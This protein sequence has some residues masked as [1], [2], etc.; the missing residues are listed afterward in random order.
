MLGETTVK[1]CKD[2]IN[3]NVVEQ[4]FYQ[5]QLFGNDQYV[6]WKKMTFN[7]KMVNTMDHLIEDK[8]A[9]DGYVHDYECKCLQEVKEAE[10][11]FARLSSLR[12]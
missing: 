3:T 4:N 2:A 8:C 7:Q 5:G 12:Q 6:E 1:R 9:I 10:E 11:Q